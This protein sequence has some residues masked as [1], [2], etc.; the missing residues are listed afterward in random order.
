MKTI[1][2]SRRKSNR[3][4]EDLSSRRRE[5]EITETT[6]SALAAAAP[7][8]S[9]VAIHAQIYERLKELIHSGELAP[10]EFLPTEPSLAA[11]WGVARGTV[12][13]ALND[14]AAEGLLDRKRGKGTWVAAPKIR[15]FLG[16]LSSFSED[17]RARGLEPGS[18][19]LGVEA[20]VP[21]LPLQQL[22]ESG[23]KK[24]WKMVRRRF[25]DSVPIAVEI[26]YVQSDR[27][28]R[29]ELVRAGGGSLYDVYRR[30]GIRPRRAVQQVEA[31][32]LEPSVAAQLEVAAG[33]AAFKQERITYG[34]DDRVI[35]IVESV[36]RGDRYKMQVD[37]RIVGVRQRGDP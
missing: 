6:R 25:A 26:C 23:D 5:H 15:H 10:G 35:D 19:L 34:D 14:L 11:M 3:H 4:L 18:E 7:N 2:Q 33:S 27:I 9:G 32:N 31:M 8:R 13:R 22:L 37:L 20:V 1:V 24:V 12:R 17:I 36:Y 29:S 21:S 30:I 16:Y 28:D